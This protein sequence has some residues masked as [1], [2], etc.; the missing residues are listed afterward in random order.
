M[1]RYIE[2]VDYSR[3]GNDDEQTM[4]MAHYNATWTTLKTIST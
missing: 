3:F 1:L 2:D 4:V